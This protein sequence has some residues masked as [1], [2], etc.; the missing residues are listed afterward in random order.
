MNGL[1]VDIL[2][3]D[4]RSCDAGRGISSKV[5]N[6]TLISSPDFPMPDTAPFEPSDDAPAVVIVRRNVCGREYLT[7]YPSDEDGNPDSDGRMASGCYIWTCDGRFR[8][9]S[10]YPVPLHDR[11]EW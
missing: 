3:H 9:I 2:K 10:P 7:A 8:E 11:K 5:N 4:G 6:A 1:R